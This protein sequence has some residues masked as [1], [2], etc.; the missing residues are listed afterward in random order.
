MII[1]KTQMQSLGDASMNNFEARMAEHL[2]RCFPETCEAEGEMGIR[3]T[4]RYGIER[5]ANHGITLERDVC[6]YIDLM[7]VF[8]PDYDGADWASAI[9]QDD[10]LD[11]ATLKTER[12]FATAKQHVPPETRSQLP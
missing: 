8:G 1:R 12:L 5:A 4:I 11:N 7:F 2:K 6:K 9:L 10:S 3:D